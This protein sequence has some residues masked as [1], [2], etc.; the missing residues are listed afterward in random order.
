MA[1]TP[2]SALPASTGLYDPANEHDAC[3]VAMV[4]TMR[5]TPGHDIVAHAM[6]ALINLEHRGA[7]GSRC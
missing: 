3:G 7:T 1:A 5:G 4:V 6:T 2:F